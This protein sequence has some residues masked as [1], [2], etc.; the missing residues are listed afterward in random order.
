VSDIKLKIDRNNLLFH[1]SLVTRN[2]RQILDTEI[3][4][5]GL[6]DATWR[7]LLHL[8]LLGD[9]IRQKELAESLGLKGPSIVRLLETLL[10]KGLIR[11]LED[12]HDR[13]AK[14]LFLTVDGRQL[15]ARIQK[16]VTSLER[17]LLDIFSDEELATL[18]GFAERLEVRVNNLL[19]KKTL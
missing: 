16:K 10:A 19:P 17:E 7:P 5:S 9:G 4:K 6:T 3:Q 15:V 8:H 12:G 13:R 14:Q 11:R 18:T 1:L 2:W